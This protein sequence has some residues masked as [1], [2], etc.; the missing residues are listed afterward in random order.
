MTN[1]VMQ[2]EIMKQKIQE[3]EER[4]LLVNLALTECE[5]RINNVLNFIAI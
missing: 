1:R 4:D 5:I 3:V 2:A